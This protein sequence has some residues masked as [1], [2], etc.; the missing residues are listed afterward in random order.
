[1]T[2]DTT[3][4]KHLV[5]NLIVAVVLVSGLLVVG[6]GGWAVMTEY[7]G[8]VIAPAQVVID[9]DLKR[10]QHPTGGV[11]A[12][13]AVR[14]GQRVEAGD[15]LI[16][17]DD[18]QARTDLAIVSKALDELVARQA[19][20]EA[21]H[22]G[23]PTV[24]FPE[25]FLRRMDETNVA[26]AVTGERQQFVSRN[27]T[28]AGQKAQ[29]TKRVLQLKEEISGYEVQFAS[30]GKQMEWVTK[31]LVG[32]NK[33]WQKHLVAYSRVTSLEREKARL[34]GERGQL[35]AFIAQTRGKVLELELQI[36]QVD[37]DLRTEVNGELS[38]IRAKKTELTEREIAARDQL[39][40][41]DMRAQ[42]S[43]VIHELDVHTIGGVIAPGE[44]V[45]LIVPEAAALIVQA[46]V[47]PQDIDQVVVDQQTI[48]R[49]T[50]FSQQSTPELNGTVSLVS[51]DVSQDEKSGAYYYTVHIAV[52]ESEVARLA[53]LQVVP[54]MPADVFIQTT[55]RTV[56]SFL[57]RPLRDQVMRAFREQ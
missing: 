8:A 52:P 13:L 26:R 45:M 22:A 27:L 11:V 57:T 34:A 20:L 9:G 15:L 17:L 33:L 19:R 6:V 43:G 28:N 47:Q 53:G 35:T 21:E 51:A 7:S 55:S 4:L 18:T 3:D 39:Q 29:L 56:I 10:I 12:E 46:R 31:E 16:R 38:E 32:I 37:F 14:D 24:L 41:I 1:M 50:A 44:P 30:K 2:P 42:L 23:L 5:R 48:V 49:L 36:K 40:R 25:K 54:G